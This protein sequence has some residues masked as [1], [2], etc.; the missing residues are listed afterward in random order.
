MPNRGKSLKKWELQEI[1]G[2]DMNKNKSF[3]KSLKCAAIGLLK[4]FVTEI[5]M[6]IHFSVAN[7]IVIF[8]YFF[9]IT[10]IEWAVLILTI[11]LVMAAELVN[12]AIEKAVDTASKEF[13]NTAKFA[14]DTA[15]GAVLFCAIISVFVGFILFFDIERI[16]TTLQYIF[17][18]A[19]VIVPCFAV[20]IADICFVIFGGRTE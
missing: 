17:M 5:N 14:K 7:L 16:A 8:A 6:R 9:G 3:L 2:N 12:T 13:S 15:A 11:A 10:R 4:P 18:N 20:G 19:R 1:D